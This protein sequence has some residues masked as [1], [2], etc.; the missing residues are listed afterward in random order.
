MHKNG[1][2]QG[3]FLDKKRREV[4][5]PKQSDKWHERGP[6]FPSEILYKGG[7]EQGSEYGVQEASG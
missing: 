4:F 2:V 7:K 5:S 3:I 1:G 6:Q